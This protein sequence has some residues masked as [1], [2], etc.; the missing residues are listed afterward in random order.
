M[1]KIFKFKLNLGFNHIPLPKCCEILSVK[2]QHG[3]IC[4][5]VKLN[6]LNQKQDRTIVAVLTGEEI[7]LEGFKFIDTCLLSNETFIIHLFEDIKS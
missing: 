7:N 3:K 4:M 1:S 6:E 2:I 5:W